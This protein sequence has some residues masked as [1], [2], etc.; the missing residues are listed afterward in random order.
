M[1]DVPA[2]D[3]LRRRRV[4]IVDDV[5]EVANGLSNGLSRL[6]YDVKIAF[7][8]EAALRMAQSF[9]PDIAL[10]DI[11]LPGMSGYE[12]ARRLK[13]DRGLCIVAMSGNA[14]DPRVES[15][16]F[17]ERFLKPFD[18]ESIHDAFLKLLDTN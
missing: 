18:L 15:P 2:T 7:D 12:L 5:A 1:A 16:I 14:C 13:A 17:E 9:Q 3:E 10:I 6:G 4:L 8:A 11:V